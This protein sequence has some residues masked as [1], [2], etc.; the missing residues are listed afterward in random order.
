MKSKRTPIPKATSEAV[1]KEYRHKCAL[2]GRHEPH[3]H[4]IDQD[5]S[6][7]TISNLLPLC[8]NCHLQDTHNPTSPPDESKLLLFR[9]YKDPLILD[10]RFHPI[11]TRS[12]F[13]YDPH[14][15]EKPHRFKYYCNELLDFIVELKMGP[16]YRKKIADHIG[17]RFSRYATHLQ[18]QGKNTTKD[19]VL[20]S[21]ELM[22]QAQLFCAERVEPL[23]VEL[24]RYQDW[25]LTFSAP[26]QA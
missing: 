14:S 1:L 25:S 21:P 19:M 8:P 22:I 7:N 5:P 18:E 6:N 13:L 20:A 26:R 23:L 24:L 11:F 3:L 10:S 15:G 4:H 9:K 17:W 12:R 16:F 2:C